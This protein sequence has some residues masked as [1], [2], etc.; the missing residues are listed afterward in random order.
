MLRVY[1]KKD[2]VDLTIT[3]PIITN[4]MDIFKQI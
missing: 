4:K 1:N 2:G 3:K